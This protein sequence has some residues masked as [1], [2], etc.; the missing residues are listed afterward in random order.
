[1]LVSFGI[2]AAILFLFSLIFGEKAAI[3]LLSGLLSLLIAGFVWFCD[4]IMTGTGDAPIF[5]GVFAIAM[6]VISPL[7]LK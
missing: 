2:S 4:G 3:L 5:W 1:M 7:L 6:C